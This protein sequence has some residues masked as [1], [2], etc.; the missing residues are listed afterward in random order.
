MELPVPSQ[1]GHRVQHDWNDTKDAVRNKQG[2][3]SIQHD[4]LKLLPW[5]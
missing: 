1:H 2:G 3:N 4:R 5:Q